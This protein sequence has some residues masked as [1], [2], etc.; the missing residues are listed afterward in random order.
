[1]A[2]LLFPRGEIVN[3]NN[4][5][6]TREWNEFFLALVRAAASSST[7]VVI[8]PPAYNDT[9]VRSLITALEAALAVEVT[10]TEGFETFVVN[11]RRTILPEIDNTLQLQ[12]RVSTDGVSAR[13][14]EILLSLS[15]IRQKHDH[16]RDEEVLKVLFSVRH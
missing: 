6:P 1:M 2:T 8:P 15:L 3:E 7:V 5:R 16:P 4:G 12:R 9:E 11:Q 14:D 13:I 10:T